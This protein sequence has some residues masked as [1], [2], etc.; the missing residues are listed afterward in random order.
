[1]SAILVEF[2]A[3]DVKVD[4]SSFTNHEL[5]AP[6][7]AKRIEFDPHLYLLIVTS[8]ESMVLCPS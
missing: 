6:L 7:L 2:E 5:I 8:V 3:Y 4:D 1:M